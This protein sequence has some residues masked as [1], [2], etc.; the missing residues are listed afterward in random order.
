MDE[1]EVFSSQVAITEVVR[2]RLKRHGVNV[3]VSGVVASAVAFSL[4]ED[5][6]SISSRTDLVV[7]RWVLRNGDIEVLESLT[8]AA[9]VAASADLLEHKGALAALAGVVV[10]LF[11]T[12]R[13]FRRKGVILPPSSLAVLVALKQNDGSSRQQLAVILRAQA[14]PVAD[15]LDAELA[16]LQGVALSDHT[17]VPLIQQDASGGWHAL[18]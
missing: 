9:V 17:V 8:D 11:R 7:R 2:D 13:A 12:L 6:G 4:E 18:V 15:E 5:E 10:A 1:H 16:L 14:E 3:E